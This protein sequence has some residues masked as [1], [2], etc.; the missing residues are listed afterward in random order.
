M[1]EETPKVPELPPIQIKTE[2][3]DVVGQC[4]VELSRQSVRLERV[5]YLD[6]CDE[7]QAFIDDAVE[8]FSVPGLKHS[9]LL[10]EIYELL[11][12][13]LWNFRRHQSHVVLEPL[14]EAKDCQIEWLWPGRI[15]AD[16]LTMLVGDPG[17]GKSLVALDIAARVSTGSSW[18][19]VPADE[20]DDTEPREPGDVLLLAEFDDVDDTIRP[21]LLAAGADLDRITLI[22]SFIRAN[23]SMDAESL[24]FSIG[25]KLDMLGNCVNR[26]PNCR[27]I[28]IDPLSAYVETNTRRELSAQLQELVEIAVKHG[29]AILVVSHFSRGSHALFHY[30]SQANSRFV[31][32]ARSVWKI[33]GDGDHRDRR[34]LLPM[35]NNLGHD[36]LGLE[37]SIEGDQQ[38]ETPRIACAHQS[39][40]INV[41]RSKFK[42]EVLE[43]P[44]SY[45]VHRKMIRQWLRQQLS[46]G[47]RFAQDV[48]AAATVARIGKRSLR[49]ALREIG[50]TTHKG[51]T[52]L[53]V[54]SLPRVLEPEIDVVEKKS[55]H[56]MICE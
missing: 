12:N 14:S 53:W 45:E 17:V 36:W 39:L 32:S 50:G 56:K 27:L 7:L 25:G 15:A 5:F 49:L 4:S 46:Q 22:R 13:E 51:S 38:D 10:N 55:H 42:P 23:D 47:E 34:V 30:G 37:F 28:V 43:L 9:H 29:V 44:N 24:P 26:L 31:A 48:L 35:K 33:L 2:L 21:R 8:K 6:D 1:T 41:E 52:G 11:N 20:S 19:D 18:P 3:L 54:W 40:E 16:K